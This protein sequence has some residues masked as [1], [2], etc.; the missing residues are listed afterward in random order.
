MTI[1]VI[2]AIA[3]MVF[4][5]ACNPMAW[6]FVAV[7]SSAP[8]IK[9]SRLGRL[10]E[11]LCREPKD[12]LGVVFFSNEKRGATG[13]HWY[14]LRGTQ[15]SVESPRCKDD[16]F[17]VWRQGMDSY[18]TMDVSVTPLEAGPEEIQ[19][20]HGGSD[21]R[22]V[23]S[24]IRAIVTDTTPAMDVYLTV[25]MTAPAILAAESGRQGGVAL[26]VPDFRSGR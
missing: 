25:E 16:G 6:M 3:F 7:F 24:F 1:A 4:M 10:L 5:I 26:D 19:S 14:E 12:F 21:W 9:R 22:P 18:E 13:H 2:D 11:W 20:G 23:E 15:A 17:R 8:R